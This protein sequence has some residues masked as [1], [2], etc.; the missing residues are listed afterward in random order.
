VPISIPESL[1]IALPPI[2]SPSSRTFVELTLVNWR[3]PWGSRRLDFVIWAGSFNFS[4]GDIIKFF[5]HHQDQQI[6][7]L[8]TAARRIDQSSTSI[9]THLHRQGLHHKSAGKLRHHYLD[10]SIYAEIFNFAQGELLIW[11]RYLRCLSGSNYPDLLSSYSSRLCIIE[12]ESDRFNLRQP[13]LSE[14]ETKSAQ[15]QPT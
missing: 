13:W 2:L 6:L 3:R 1:V 5:L 14:I 15:L 11:Q 4:I 12:K 9:K 7:R 10:A 8:R